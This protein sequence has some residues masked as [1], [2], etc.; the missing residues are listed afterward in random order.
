MGCVRFFVESL[1]LAGV[2]VQTLCE[3]VWGLKKRTH[4]LN[5]VRFTQSE[6]Q[7]RI[8]PGIDNGCLNITC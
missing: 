8:E 2:Q 6:C 4:C 7:H 1:V 3:N 5:G